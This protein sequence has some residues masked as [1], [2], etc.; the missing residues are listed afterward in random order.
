[1]LDAN[2]IGDYDHHGQSSFRR[3]PEQEALFDLALQRFGRLYENDNDELGRKKRRR[4]SSA[5]PQVFNATEFSNEDDDFN[6][7]PI[8]NG[9]EVR[10]AEYPWT[11]LLG[12]YVSSGK[13]KHLRKP[14]RNL[15]II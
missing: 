9:A 12:K 1:M 4:R 11:V 10:R 15:T 2:N 3:P 13:S 6:Q 8:V 14:H 7:V 5:F